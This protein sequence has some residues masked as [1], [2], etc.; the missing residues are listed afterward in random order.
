MKVVKYF[1]VHRKREKRGHIDLEAVKGRRRQ[2]CQLEV[3]LTF[4]LPRSPP[5]SPTLFATPSQG[6]QPKWGEI[7]WGVQSFFLSPLLLFLAWRS[8]Y[9]DKAWVLHPCQCPTLPISM[10]ST[11]TQCWLTVHIVFFSACERLYLCGADK[12]HS[13]RSEERLRC[14]ILAPTHW[15][16]LWPSL[17]QPHTHTHCR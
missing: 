13:F 10:V 8:I 12:Y 6:G 2:C 11:Q 14:V 3:S 16:T 4:Q 17:N 5:P 1:F 15:S 7:K 9:G